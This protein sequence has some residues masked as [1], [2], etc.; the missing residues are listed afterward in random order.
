[1]MW[2]SARYNYADNDINKSES[3]KEIETTNQF[4]PLKGLA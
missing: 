1:M 2:S 3:E 4:D